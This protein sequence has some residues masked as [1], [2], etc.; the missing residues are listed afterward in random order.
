MPIIDSEA[1]T[2][3]GVLSH[4]GILASLLGKFS[5]AR[6]LFDFP[7]AS[8]G[9]GTFSDV[10]VVPETASVIS[11]LN[12]LAER[13]ISSVPLV[14][15]AGQV[16]DVFLREDVTFLAN[17]P[18]LLVL[19]APVGEVRRA[20][21]SMMGPLPPLL[22]CDR[23]DTL[24]RALEL[25]AVAQG[26][27]KILVCVDAHRR[28]TGIVTLSDIFAFVAA[29][30]EEERTSGEEEMAGGGAGGG[31][32]GAGGGGGG[33]G[34]A[35]GGGGGGLG[36]S[37]DASPHGGIIEGFTGGAAR[38]PAMSNGGGGDAGALPVSGAPQPGALSP[39]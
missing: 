4:R 8:L 13:R 30:E 6:R 19:D 27:V 20:Q 34:R 14:N 28:C 15:E 1:N 21:A 39:A 25:F 32:G 29:T 17:D 5:D 22:T 10:V 33:G 35:G 11:V 26:A 2:V 24:Q 3:V 37:L 36:L 7:L 31:G 12:V 9:I 23:S 16:T 18:S 38:A